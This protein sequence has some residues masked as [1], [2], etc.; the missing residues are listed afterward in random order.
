MT[1]LSYPTLLVLLVGFIKLLGVLVAVTWLQIIIYKGLGTTK[2]LHIKLTDMKTEEVLK[3]KSWGVIVALVLAS[4]LIIQ[5]FTSP[6]AMIYADTE[7]VN[8][9]MVNTQSLSVIIIFSLLSIALTF[10]AKS[11]NLRYGS[12]TNIKIIKLLGLVGKFLYLL[13]GV[14]LVLTWLPLFFYLAEVL[15]M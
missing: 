10:M 6:Y 11:Y 13:S 1:T 2:K 9:L 12:K 4:V 3:E 5:I 7:V 8:A 15:I 14:M